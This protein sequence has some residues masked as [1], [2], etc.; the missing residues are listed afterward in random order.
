MKERETL[1]PHCSS[2]ASYIYDFCNVRTLYG[3][4]HT[5]I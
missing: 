4:T 5:R 3:C 1:S 2:A